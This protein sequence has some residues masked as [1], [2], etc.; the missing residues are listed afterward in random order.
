MAETNFVA[1]LHI[2]IDVKAAL[3]E[4]AIRIAEEK[5]HSIVMSGGYDLTV[6]PASHCVRG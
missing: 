5:F 4:D 1:E 3:R 6:M 2:I